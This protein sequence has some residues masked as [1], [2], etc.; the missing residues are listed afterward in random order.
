MVHEKER[1]ENGRR[2]IGI[3]ILLL[4]KQLIGYYVSPIRTYNG[5]FDIQIHT[6]ETRGEQRISRP[7]TK[8]AKKPSF[9]ITRI[10]LFHKL[11]LCARYVSFDCFKKEM[12]SWLTDRLFSA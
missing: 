9:G 8:L 2:G 1:G 3:D 5:N 7:Y 4:E 6:H 12:Y 10:R 11:P